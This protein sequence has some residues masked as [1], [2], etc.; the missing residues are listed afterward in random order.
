MADKMLS[1][2]EITRLLRVRMSYLLVLRLRLVFVAALD[3]CTVEKLEKIHL[4]Q[5]FV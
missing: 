3:M 4:S 2:E 1:T 5:N